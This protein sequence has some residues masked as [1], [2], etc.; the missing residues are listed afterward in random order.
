[1]SL[2]PWDE[3]YLHVSNTSC[4]CN[5]LLCR[6]FFPSHRLVAVMRLWVGG[7]LSSP[8]LAQ[9][10]IDDF[11]MALQSGMDQRTLAILISMS[12]LAQRGTQKDL[13]HW[14]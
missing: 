10:D 9:Q 4:S 3:S 14:S 8:I 11:S 2:G 12:H 5:R 6:L 1:M 13:Q 7:D